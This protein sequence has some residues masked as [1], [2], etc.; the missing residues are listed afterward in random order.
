MQHIEANRINLSY[1]NKMLW[2]K[3]PVRTFSSSADIK[4][5]MVRNP[6]LNYMGAWLL[7]GD[8]IIQSF[9][10]TG[11]HQLFNSRTIN[12]PDFIFPVPATNQQDLSFLLLIDKRN[13][14]LN[15]PVHLLTEN[16]FLNYNFK[17]N[18][19]AGVITGLGLFLFLFSFF[20]FYNMRER[21]Y[22]YYGLYIFMVF[23]YIFSDYGLSFM[24]FFP[25]HPFPA[26]FTR[27]LAVSLA[28]PLY[29][30][31]ALNL[32]NVKK[33]MPVHYKWSRWYLAVYL[34]SLLISLFFMPE[35]G[36]LRVVLVWLMQVY[37]NMTAL[38]MLFIAVLAYRKKIPYAAYIIGTSIVLLLSFFFFMQFVSGYLQD[39][40]LT[41]NLMNIGFTAEISVLAFVLTLRF[42]NYKEQSEQLLRT[43]NLQQEQ[44][45]K[46]ISD[47]QQKEMQRYS[48]LLHDSVGAQ[49][50]AIR[51]NLESIQKN[52][53]NE[54]IPE[55]MERSIKDVSRLA[56]EVRQ[57]S[58]TLSPVLLQKHGLVETLKEIVA[59]IN[60]SEG[61]YIQFESIGTLQSASFQYELLTYNIV[62]E[63]IQNIIKHAQA[64]EA[65]VQ[66]ILEKEL[67]CLFV[68]DNGRGFDPFLIK[69]GLGFSQIKQL[70]TFVKGNFQ[71]DADKNNGCRIS[72]EFPVLPDETKHPHSNS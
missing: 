32:L 1:E 57:F 62:Q 36:S 26:D 70:V 7:K 72:I 9:N 55:R 51:L 20:L 34:L 10:L 60:E 29:M 52:E 42:R 4:Y 21:L 71:V 24:Y 15:I 22:I 17:K 65:I 49:L 13:E 27:P 5:L 19:L 66:L 8:S 48:S 28:T 30:L 63:L 68:E 12:H 37:Q 61:L 56:D 59:G 69:E 58:H 53:K 45:F 38:W 16:G 39:S 46:T 67:I 11:D 40:F 47:Y 18:L 44:I 31:F 43:T 54:P 14:Q 64:T 3:I 33:T 2:I 23:F 25:N 50:S 41:R 35:T 6:H